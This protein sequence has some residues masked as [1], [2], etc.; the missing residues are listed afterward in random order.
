MCALGVN[1]DRPQ[2]PLLAPLLLVLLLPARTNGQAITVSPQNGLVTT[3]AGGVAQFTMVLT[4]APTHDVT[5]P[6]ATS[7]PSESFVSPLS[8]TFSPTNF[9]T[10]Q[11][12]TI[13]GV[14][15]DI[16]DGDVSFVVQTGPAVSSD[17]SYNNFNPADVRVTN[18]DDDTAGITVTTGGLVTS[19]GGGRVT[20]TVVLDSRPFGSGASI[21]SI[22]ISSQDTTEGTVT[23][24]SLTFTSGNWNTP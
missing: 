24:A 16:D 13:T 22:P 9:A 3:E 1:A 7:D 20:F 6:V 12:V 14:N 21:V 18:T 15:D 10:A 23:P 2:S 11:T 17:A 8:L 19:E 5:I 4:T